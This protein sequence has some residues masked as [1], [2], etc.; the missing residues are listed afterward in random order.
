[1]KLKDGYILRNIA[2]SWIVVPLGE[3]VVEFNGLLS[4]NETAA[5]LWKQL[6]NE[7]DKENLCS[8][9]MKEYEVDELIAKKDIDDFLQVLK[10]K[11]LI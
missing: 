6:E 1:M 5:F 10:E 3:R 11:E 7:C 4:L 2:D 9:L 8:A